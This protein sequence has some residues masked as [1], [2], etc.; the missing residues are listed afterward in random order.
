MRRPVIFSWVPHA[1]WELAY[2]PPPYC[3]SSRTLA[4]PTQSVGNHYCIARKMK[5]GRLSKS[6]DDTGKWDAPVGAARSDLYAHQPDHK[7]PLS[8]LSQKRGGFNCGAGRTHRCRKA[9]LRRLRHG[10]TWSRWPANT[11]ADCASF[12]YFFDSKLPIWWMTHPWMSCS[13]FPKV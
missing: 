5:Q 13:V 7:W 4:F 10:T 8:H 12:R 9:V 3:E 6:R 1:R 2:R 11:P